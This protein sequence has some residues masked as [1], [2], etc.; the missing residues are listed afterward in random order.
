MWEWSGCNVCHS[1]DCKDWFS[2]SGCLGKR[3]LSSSA[4]HVCPSQSC[5][6]TPRA[7]PPFITEDDSLIERIYME[8]C[9]LLKSVNML[10]EAHSC[11][12]YGLRSADD[13]KA[14][15]VH[16]FLN[17]TFI[18]LWNRNL[19]MHSEKHC[20]AWQLI[21]SSPSLSVWAAL[22][23]PVWCEGCAVQYARAMCLGTRLQGK[24]CQKHLTF[25]R[26]LIWN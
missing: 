4:C 1:T 25:L 24:R 7:R 2:W 18:L 20:S 15:Q 19:S 14:L 23:D 13:Q 8:V 12:M 26:R 16:V 3:L 21:L 10:S 22:V 5:A 17:W 11:A 9:P 6:C